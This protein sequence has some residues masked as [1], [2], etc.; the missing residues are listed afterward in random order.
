[1]FT[2]TNKLRSVVVVATV[3]AALAFSG[4]ASAAVAVHQPGT[5][6]ATATAP[7]VV[8]D[9]APGNVGSAGVPGWDDGTCQAVA[10]EAN[11]WWAIGD[12]RGASGDLQG[13]ARAYLIANE[14][15]AEVRDNCLVVD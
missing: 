11:N 6:A 2:I 9:L 14:L 7:P 13:Q 10:Q 8:S 15:D 12:Q 3:G 1:M 5:V 4:V